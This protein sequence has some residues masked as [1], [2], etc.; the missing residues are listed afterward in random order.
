MC[1]YR[2][3]LGREPPTGVSMTRFVGHLDTHLVP[4][5]TP[6]RPIPLIKHEGARSIRTD[7]AVAIADDL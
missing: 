5:L 1:I 7:V 2:H 6:S 4:T 3:M